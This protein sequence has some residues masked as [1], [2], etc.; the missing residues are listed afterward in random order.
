MLTGS[1]RSV[2]ARSSGLRLTED[3]LDG[4][5]TAAE[6]GQRCAYR[7]LTEYFLRVA[8][9]GTW[10]VNHLVREAEKWVDK[11]SGDDDKQTDHVDQGSEGH[12]VESGDDK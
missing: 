6:E 4:R 1:A 3:H 12:T 10:L 11:H 5:G 9:S 8:A 7:S 2:Q